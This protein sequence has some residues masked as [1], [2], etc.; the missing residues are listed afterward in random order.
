M[1]KQMKVVIA[2]PGRN[3]E[4]TIGQV[5]NEL[6]EKFRKHMI[7]SDDKS[8][9]RTKEIA[10]KLGIKVFLNPMQPGYGSNVKNCFNRALGEGADIVV[11][12]HSDNQ[13]DPKMV[14][15]LVKPIEDEKADFTIGSRILGDKAKG[16]PTA[17]FIGNRLLGFAENLAMGTSLTDLH[18]GMI[19]V[20]AELLKKIPYNNNSDDHGFHTDIVLQSRYAGARFKEIGIPT[21]YEEMNTSI[22]AYKS[23][24]YGFRTM[25]MV[26][27]YLLH[28]FKL[29]KFREFMIRK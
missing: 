17:R 6:P 12:L 27:K 22:T 9:D 13:Y 1:K 18:S 10:G 5:Y 15:L 24:I 4:K 11:V 14:P 8:T 19:A 3:S 29:M 26:V 20:R 16:M 7:L 25:Q 28:K 2:I 23:I 21:R